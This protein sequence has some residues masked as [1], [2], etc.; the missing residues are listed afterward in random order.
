MDHV[1]FTRRKV[2]KKEDS[3]NSKRN[4]PKFDTLGFLAQNDGLVS[5]SLL[6]SHPDSFNSSNGFHV[7]IGNGAIYTV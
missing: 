1:L 2:N 4:L 7:P 3:K 6:Q 5:F